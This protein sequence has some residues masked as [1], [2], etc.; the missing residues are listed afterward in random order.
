MPKFKQ[1]EQAISGPPALCTAA[2]LFNLGLQIKCF[3][4]FSPVLVVDIRKCDRIFTSL[5]VF[6]P[7]P[8]AI[9]IQLGVKKPCH[10]HDSPNSCLCLD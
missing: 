5:L 1:N 4:K 2:L 8:I 10:S 9:Q 7:F 6:F 3:R